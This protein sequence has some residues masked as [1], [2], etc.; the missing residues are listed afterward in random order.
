MGRARAVCGG[1]RDVDAA[2]AVPAVW[3]GLC[4]IANC[5]RSRLPG[6]FGRP[7]CEVEGTMA[8]DGSGH[9]E[10]TGSP[11]PPP[12]GTALRKSA[13]LITGA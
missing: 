10:S 12:A 7:H 9:F 6:K 11:S 4:G 3:L 13:P 5:G 2:D 8:T 1:G